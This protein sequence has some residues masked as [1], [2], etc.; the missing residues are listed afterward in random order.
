MKT[1]LDKY[2]SGYTFYFKV[3]RLCFQLRQYMEMATLLRYTTYEL[4]VNDFNRK[5]ASTRF[6]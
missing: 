5:I 1:W 3:R 2:A 6:R 4:V